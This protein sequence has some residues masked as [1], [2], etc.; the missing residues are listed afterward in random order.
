MTTSK[1]IYSDAELTNRIT[2]NSIYKALESDFVSIQQIESMCRTMYRV[3]N[4]P[5]H[6]LRRY[7]R[8]FDFHAEVI[9]TLVRSSTQRL[10]PKKVRFN[11]NK[12]AFIIVNYENNGICR[13]VEIY[14]NAG[15]KVKNE[16]KFPGFKFWNF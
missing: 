12:P 6:M 14:Y 9:H 15:Y 4:S 3:G 2:M 7:F 10:D 8:K 5:T 11:K 1:K 13:K 16:S